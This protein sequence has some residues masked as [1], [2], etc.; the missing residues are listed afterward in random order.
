MK[1]KEELKNWIILILVAVVSFCFINNLSMFINIIKK[2]FIVISPFILGFALAYILNIPMVKIE[3]QLKKKIKNKKV[4]IRIISI[5]LSLIIFIAVILFVAFMLIPELIE[6]IELLIQNIPLL[7]DKVE[8]WILDLLSEYP[9]IQSKINDMFSDTSTTNIIMTILNYLLNSSISFVS[10]LVSSVITIFTALVFAI[11]MLSQKEYLIKSIK[12]IMNAYVNKKYINKIMEISKQT[13]YVF[14]KF[15]SGQCVEAV[16]LGCIFFIV[17]NI[18]RFPYAL[19]ISVITS[20]TSLI[21]I[22]GAFIAMVIGAILIAITNP[23]QSL[24]FMIVFV[25]VQQIEGNL[26]YPRVVGK[27]VGL[28][29]I[30]TLLAVTV[31]GGLFGIIGMLIGLP[32]ASVIYSLIVSDVN[33]RVEE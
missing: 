14:T 11:Y 33:K 22:F 27:S 15:I 17:L 26:I 2:I 31:G 29:P 16:I 28:S 12:K 18:F 19:I 9:E 30:L 24:I 21:P 20:I 13:N 23:I 6:N 1:T 7:I 25:V 10:S 5:T 8:V 3:K 4:P 32:I